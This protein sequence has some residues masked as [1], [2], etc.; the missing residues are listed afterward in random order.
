MDE[1]NKV[2]V[3]MESGELFRQICDLV[4][5]HVEHKGCGI[6]LDGIAETENSGRYWIL[7]GGNNVCCQ[8]RAGAVP[9]VWG[10][11]NENTIIFP[12]GVSVP[13]EL[14]DT[15]EYIKEPG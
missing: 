15:T 5:S 1:N 8:I 14:I 3:K 10:D 11:C 9:R 7:R 12:N 4:F 6:A 13:F 2:C